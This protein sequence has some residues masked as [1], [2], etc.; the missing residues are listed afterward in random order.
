MANINVGDRFIIE[1]WCKCREQFALNAR[2]FDLTEAT[3]TM[4]HTTE[5]LLSYVNDVMVEY[6]LRYLPTEALYYGTRITRTHPSVDGPY[7][8]VSS[9][10]GTIASLS[11]PPQ[12]AILIKYD[13]G[14]LG[15]RNR[16]RT[17]LPFPPVAFMGT[18]GRL[19]SLG[20][21]RTLNLRLL[22]V[23]GIEF[24]L[25]GEVGMLK[26]VVRSSSSAAGRP[27]INSSVVREFASMRSRSMMYGS[28]TA[29]FI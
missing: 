11:L 4:P 17:Y 15:R 19:T 6:Y 14:M 2:T 13:T 10:L 7:H 25:G 27:Y 22:P 24:V 16:G 9:L 23:L 12:V 28:D 8:V 26:Q 1:S 5:D 18:N 29:P 21:T 20:V 3:F